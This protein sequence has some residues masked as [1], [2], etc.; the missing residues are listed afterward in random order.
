MICRPFSI[1][2]ARDTS[3]VISTIT[4]MIGITGGWLYRTF[5]FVFLRRR[6]N[7]DFTS[8][9]A[10]NC[11]KTDRKREGSPSSEVLRQ[12]DDGPFPPHSCV[13]ELII[14][15]HRTPLSLFLILMYAA[16]SAA[17]A[18]HSEVVGAIT[19]GIH[20]DIEALCGAHHPE[21]IEPTPD[22]RYLIATAFLDEHPTG[23]VGGG[24]DLFDLKKKTFSRMT[25]IDHPDRSWGD[26]AC[27]GPIDDAMVSHGESLAKR[28]NGKWALYVVNH[29]RRES[30]EMF[31][32]TQTGGR[33]TL[34]W[35]G[36]EIGNHP[37]NDVAILPDG[38]FVGTQPMALLRPGE[39]ITHGTGIT[40]YVA[41]W[42]PGEG[43]SEITTTRMRFPNGIL[44]SPDGRYMYVNEFLGGHVLKVDLKDGKRVGSINVDFLPDNLTWTPQGDMLSAG[45]K[46]GPTE[47]CPKENSRP[48]DLSF[49]IVEINPASMQIRRQYDSEGKDIIV[50]G[51]TVALRVG[52]DLIL[53]RS[54]AISS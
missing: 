16:S 41:H 37:Y 15:K 11:D 49:G 54:P 8:R 9:S 13:T 44:V 2:R 27:P 29:A 12:S 42:A 26:P 6:V 31:E 25:I 30:I 32:L 28:N 17:Q 34:I 18:G 46:G 4:A 3:T 24:L 21:D 48:C 33:W 14:V 40:G 35:R 19:C 22:G 43:E 36:C 52:D 1:D 7:H 39:K 10:L 53:V 45:I 20:S 5:P 38:G 23:L 50:A 51:V 47:K